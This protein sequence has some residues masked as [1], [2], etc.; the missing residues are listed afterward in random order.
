MNK[1]INRADLNKALHSMS[2]QAGVTMAELMIAIVLGL[3]VTAAALAIF[4]GGQRSLNAQNGM[5]SLQQS[6][7][8]G[9]SQLTYHVRHANLNTTLDQ[10]VRAAPAASV[11]GSGIVFNINNFP[12]TATTQ[13]ESTRYT[14][15][16]VTETIMNV[17]SDILTIQYKPSYTEQAIQNSNSVN[18][19]SNMRD[20]EGNEISYL[21][22]VKGAEF[23]VVHRFFIA[24]V[25]EAQQNAARDRYALYCDASYYQANNITGSVEDDVKGNNI[26]NGQILIP[27]VDAFKVRLGVKD[28][29]GNLRY[30]TIAQYTAG[31]GD[32]PREPQVPPT[33]PIPEGATTAPL[34]ISHNNVV[35]IEL[36]ILARSPDTVGADQ[37]IQAGRVYNLAGT[38]IN[39]RNANEQAPKYLR[40]AFNE[41]VALRNAQGGVN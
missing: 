5:S 15:G 9:L 30:M 7:I 24:L 10:R 14:Q 8:F 41:V 18:Y 25:P 39:L 34:P 2:K 23:I 35:S 12:T 40:E 16:V 32:N 33:P 22:K 13:R 11:V 37:N 21:N 19:R 3:L 4:L 29:T 6:A 20:C 27:D 28:A 38:G 1:Q 26:G 36:G 17:N 31:L